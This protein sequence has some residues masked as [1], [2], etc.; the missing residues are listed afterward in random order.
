MIALTDEGQRTVDAAVADHV[1]NE[2]ALLAGLTD[3][4]QGE[5]D[6]LVRKLLASLPP[7]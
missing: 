6:D 2:A 1:A 3:A 4:E 5:L 7:T